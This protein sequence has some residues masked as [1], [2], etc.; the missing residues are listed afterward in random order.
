M[1]TLKSETWSYIPVSFFICYVTPKNLLNVS[2]FQLLKYKI[3]QCDVIL[4]I[5]FKMLN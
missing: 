3:W 2:D 1:Q 5:A 4:R